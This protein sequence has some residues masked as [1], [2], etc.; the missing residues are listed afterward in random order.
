MLDVFCPKQSCART[1]CYTCKGRGGGRVEGEDNHTID[2]F[3]AGDFAL[4]LLLLPKNGVKN[5]LRKTKT[6]RL[7]K[8]KK[9]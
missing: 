7:K 6:L 1:H 8:K 9:D 3:A 4:K 5:S 2:P